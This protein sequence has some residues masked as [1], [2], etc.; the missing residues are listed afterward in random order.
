MQ[1]F[2]D[3]PSPR[4]PHHDNGFI[5]K[6]DRVNSLV[7]AFIY[8]PGMGVGDRIDVYWD[9]ELFYTHYV[10]RSNIKTS[11]VKLLLRPSLLS[12]GRHSLKYR[13]TDV[14]NNRSESNAQD[15]YIN[16]YDD[17]EVLEAA[18]VLGVECNYL[19][20]DK[21]IEEQGVTVQIDEPNLSALDGR[22]LTALWIG[23][24]QSGIPSYGGEFVYKAAIGREVQS[25]EF[26][27]PWRVALESYGGMAKIH[28]FVE[29]G[30]ERIYSK[31]VSVHIGS[32]V[33][34]ELR[35]IISEGDNKFTSHGRAE[36]D[37]KALVLDA[38]HRPVVH[39]KVSWFATNG[40]IS[41]ISSYSG[42]DGYA[43][44]TVFGHCD[45]S[46]LITGILNSGESGQTSITLPAAKF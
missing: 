24:G 5:T 13:V 3:L 22:T 18:N 29:L 27:V 30:N 9:Y 34:Q 36:K 10:S 43:H 41:P 1:T 2:L 40:S 20:I 35:L 4:I 46:M 12:E 19:P 23:Y 14:A 28:Y 45:R 26:I 42:L 17:K 25:I 16:K 8:Y 15:I 39:Q 38:N 6:Y 31:S 37:V 44:S 7:D 11:C 32:Y 33:S 21:I